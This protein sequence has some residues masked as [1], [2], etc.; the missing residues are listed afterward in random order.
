MEV[1][2]TST[3]EGHV[4]AIK[5][6]ETG[7]V[8]IVEHKYLAALAEE[9]TRL[10][11]IEANATRMVIR[12][13]PEV[14]GVGISPW[15]PESIIMMLDPTTDHQLAISWPAASAVHVAND[16]KKN[17]VKIQSAVERTRGLIVPRHMMK[18]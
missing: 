9:T 1:K 5:D 15:D 17:A 10:R 8:F 16:I 12:R 7:I 6:G 18:Q 4:I 3:E 11:T 13:E 14:T 2:T